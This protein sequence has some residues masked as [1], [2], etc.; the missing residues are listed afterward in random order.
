MKS[1]KS[2]ESAIRQL[3]A[4]E[5]LRQQAILLLEQELNPTTKKKALSAEQK[6]RI[7]A[8]FYKNHVNQ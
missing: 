6:Q 1:N 7:L 8:R 2:I 3:K 5:A 4:G